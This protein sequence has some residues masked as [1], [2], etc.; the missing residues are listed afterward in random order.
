MAL[1]RVGRGA[2]VSLRPTGRSVERLRPWDG[3]THDESQPLNHGEHGGAR[4]K[5]F[6]REDREEGAKGA[7]KVLTKI[8]KF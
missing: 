1:D 3:E 4:R 8:L 2:L 5:A 7:K 6:N